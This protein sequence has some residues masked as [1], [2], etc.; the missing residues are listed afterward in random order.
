MKDYKDIEAHLARCSDT[1]DFY[2]ESG[3][4]PPDAD[5]SDPLTNMITDTIDRNPLAEGSDPLWVD[6]IKD[7]LM[8]YFNQLL[9]A[10]ADI[11]QAT[12]RELAI[13]DEFEAADIEK[14]RQMWG[15]ICKLIQDKYTRYQVDMPGFTQQFATADRDAVFSAMISDW[16]NACID[17]CVSRQHEMHKASRVRW[18]ISMGEIASVDYKER[19]KIADM[20]FRYPRL[21]EIID[22]IGREHESTDEEDNIVYSFLPAGARTGLPSEDID[23]IENG[24]DLQRTI[25][26]EFAMPDDLFYKKYAVKELQQL[27]PPR[28]RK[29]K[30]TEE[31][32]PKPRPKKGPIIV[33]VDT[34]GSM[35]GQPEKVAKALVVELVKMA[36]REHRSCYLITFSVRTYSIDLGKSGNIVALKNFLDEH[37]TGGNGE[38]KLLAQA[39]RILD[40]NEYEMADILLISDFIFNGP[41]EAHLKKVEKAKKLGTRFYGLQINSGSKAYDA[42]LD[43]KWNC[44]F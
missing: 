11:Q 1:F 13:I 20:V 16:R 28:Q 5:R 3:E 36:R 8:G 10:F 27:A 24:N 9:G 37:F 21:Q 7:N 44:S 30:K 22:I 4:L 41:T 40:T 38:E 26:A 23:S 42:V 35:Y 29:P 19:R 39:L 31:H 12:E 15:P 6:V 32:R 2:M 17:N 34:S 43:K 18:E 33:G 14:K 25:V